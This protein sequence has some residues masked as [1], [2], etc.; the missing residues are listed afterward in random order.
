MPLIL[1]ICHH[2]ILQSPSG[3]ISRAVLVQYHLLPPSLLHSQNLNHTHKDV[4]EVELQGDGLV[5]GVLLHEA[6][7]GHAGVGEDLLHVV[8]SEA[9]EDLDEGQSVL[10]E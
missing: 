2:S 1:S 4:D 7:L 10:I 5:Y 6:T 3:H 9:A 8:E